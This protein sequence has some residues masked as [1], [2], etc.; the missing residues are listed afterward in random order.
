MQQEIQKKMFY[1]PQNG[2][3]LGLMGVLTPIVATLIIALLMVFIAFGAGEGF[4][5][6]FDSPV[7]VYITQVLCEGAFVLALFIFNKKERRA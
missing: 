7:F 6:M 2:F 5:K 3:V 1:T 4:E